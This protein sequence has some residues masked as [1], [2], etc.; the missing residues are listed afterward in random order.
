MSAS[1]SIDP[2]PGMPRAA[3]G[4]RDTRGVCSFPVLPVGPLEITERE[5]AMLRFPQERSV[6]KDE[7]ARA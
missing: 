2:A 6:R 3:V 4:V 1:T 7:E 5:A